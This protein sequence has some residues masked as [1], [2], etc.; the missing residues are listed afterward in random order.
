MFIRDAREDLV[1]DV[2]VFLS[3]CHP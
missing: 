1:V 2:R 3:C